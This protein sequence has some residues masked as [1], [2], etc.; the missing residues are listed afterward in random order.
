MSQPI[1]KTPQLERLRIAL[2][3]AV[4]GLLAFLLIGFAIREIGAIGGPQLSDFEK[5]YVEPPLVTGLAETDK[6][7][8]EIAYA[9]DD[10]REHQRLLRESADRFA[11][12]IDELRELQRDKAVPFGEAEQKR[13]A[14]AVELF[15]FNQ[16]R[17]QEI[18]ETVTALAEQRSML[19][20]KKRT[21][22]DRL[23]Q[24]RAAAQRKFE[25]ARYEHEQM[26]SG[27]KLGLFATLFGFMALVY[28]KLDAPLESSGFCAV[29]AAILARM[30][31]DSRHFPGWQRYLLP[32]LVFVVVA[33]LLVRL[34]D[35]V[36][37]PKGDA[38]LQKR[39]E[40][41]AAGR[42]PSCDASFGHTGGTA[43][44]ETC[45][46]CGTKL[47]EECPKCKA[48]RHSLLPFCE[49]CGTDKRRNL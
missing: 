2:F 39:S 33:R 9:T 5:K 32:A 12:T 30:I 4:L 42:C 28:F 19:T 37:Y 22:E 26:L 34:V 21:D 10:D 49:H 13:L 29:S 6:Q 44:P 24:Q 31:Y 16:N 7:L 1:F 18:S 3:A 23:A 14:E 47:F 48:P 41:Y 35:A 46:T 15:L 40:S 8:R 27:F 36:R 11:K 38:L 20:E 43:E 45:A 17:D 25:R